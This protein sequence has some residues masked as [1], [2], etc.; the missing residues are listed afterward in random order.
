[1][2]GPYRHD[3]ELDPRKELLMGRAAAVTRFA[4]QLYQERALT[5][6]Y[7]HARRDPMAL[8]R[9]RPGREDPYPIYEQ[10][11]AREPLVPTRLGNWV[12][13]SHEVRGQVL[14]DRRMG[15][16]PDKFEPSTSGFGMSFLELNPPDPTRLRRLQPTPRSSP[17]SARRSAAHWTASR[18]CRTPGR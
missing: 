18:R 15:V 13:T 7:G 16:R 3:D 1:V 10:L 11:R 12:S 14:R 9:M 5:A 8:L 17:A 6:Y 4:S 2:Q